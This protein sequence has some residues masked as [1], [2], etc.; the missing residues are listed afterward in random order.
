MMMLV[1]AS[2]ATRIQNSITDAMSNIKAEESQ[3]F[4]HAAE[5]LETNHF[6]DV[7]DI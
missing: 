1:T 7:D 4:M 2:I 5:H 3:H 6:F